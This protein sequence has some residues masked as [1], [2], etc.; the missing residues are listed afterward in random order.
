[1]EDEYE[2]GQKSEDIARIPIVVQGALLATERA[3][4]EEEYEDNAGRFEGYDARGW[5]RKR[6]WRGDP[7]RTK[8]VKRQVSIKEP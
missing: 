6:Q 7:T 3:L 2:T 1:M 4:C 5:A 8:R